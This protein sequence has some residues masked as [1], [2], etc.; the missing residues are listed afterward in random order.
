MSQ[1]SQAPWPKRGLA[2][3][4]HAAMNHAPEGATDM[5]IL[6]VGYAA[7]EEERDVREIWRE[8]I[9]DE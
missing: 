9:G 5:E 4:T 2:G 6:S 7:W 8:V 3:K 1:E